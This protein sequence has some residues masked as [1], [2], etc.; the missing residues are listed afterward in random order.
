[1][2]LIPGGGNMRPKNQKLAERATLSILS[3]EPIGYDVWGCPGLVD[4]KG[5][6][7]ASL[8]WV[9]PGDR[10]KDT[11]DTKFAAR[12]RQRGSVGREDFR[13]RRGE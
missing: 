9:R 13:N 2:D 1:V 10:I 12:V 6:D 8:S 4:Y 3:A 5:G 7:P 11:T